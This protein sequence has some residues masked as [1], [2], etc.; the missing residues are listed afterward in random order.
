MRKIILVSI[1]IA[2][3]IPV[4]AYSQEYTLQADDFGTWNADFTVWTWGPNFNTQRAAVY[5]CS[6]GSGGSFMTMSPDMPDCPA[7]SGIDCCSGSPL[8]EVDFPIDYVGWA[9]SP[10]RDFQEDCFRW[11]MEGEVKMVPSCQWVWDEQIQAIQLICQ[12]TRP[13]GWEG[14]T[15]YCDSEPYLYDGG[16]NGAMISYDPDEQVCEQSC[17]AKFPEGGGSGLPYPMCWE[18]QPGEECIGVSMMYDARYYDKTAQYVDVMRQRGGWH[19]AVSFENFAT[20]PPH[21]VTLENLRTGAKYISPPVDC[22]NFLGTNICEAAITI[23]HNWPAEGDWQFLVDGN[24][25]HQATADMEIPA[26]PVIKLKKMRIKNNGDLVV[27]FHVPEDA[28]GRELDVRLRVLDGDD[29]VF[30]QKFVAPFTFINSDGVEKDKVKTIIP[31]QYAGMK[32]RLEVRVS[33]PLHMARTLVW[34][35]LPQSLE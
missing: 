30:Q 19:L 26:L 10:H 5:E 34:F 31:A 20:S 18:V 9:V 2:C 1:L 21:Q 7:V 11:T 28:D 14:S 25:V 4:A 3:L 15:L 29:F 22:Y 23:G 27:N 6:D 32:A 12:E 35:T 24:V 16:L 8:A 13:T 17:I 33:G